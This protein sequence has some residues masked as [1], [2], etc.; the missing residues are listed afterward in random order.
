MRRAAHRSRRAFSLLEMLIALAITSL[1][2][3]ACLAAL[4]TTFKSYKMTRHYWRGGSYGIHL[5]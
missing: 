5:G 4:D 2:L 1:L 3:T